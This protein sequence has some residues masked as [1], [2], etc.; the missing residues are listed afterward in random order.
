MGNTKSKTEEAR[1]QNLLSKFTDDERGK[2]LKR[3]KEFGK[4][5][6]ENNILDEGGTAS[7]HHDKNNRP[8]IEKCG[9]ISVEDFKQHLS[10]VIT[11]SLRQGFAQYFQIESSNSWDY[12][13]SKLSEK[14]G[15]LSS[16]TVSITE[17]GFISAIY[18]LLRSN[19]IDQA[20]SAFIIC[21]AS[22]DGGAL[23]TFVQDV[24]R[25]ALAYWFEGAQLTSEVIETSKTIE[26]QEF[27]SDQHRLV[28]YL[29]LFP[30][31]SSLNPEDF[32]RT[33]Q[34][35]KE[36]S[37]DE[38]FDHEAFV[39]WY[40]NNIPFKH[41]FGI[42]ITHIFLE[43]QNFPYSNTLNLTQLKALRQT[44]LISA[45]ISS[46]Y[47]LPNF[48]RL[49]SVADYFVLAQYLPGDCRTSPMPHTLLFSSK[50]DGDS[51]QTFMNSFLYKGSTLIIVR[52]KDGHVFGGFAYQDWE[53][54]PKFFGSEQNF[55]FTIKPRLRCFPASAGYNENWQY[56][57]VGM[58]TLPNGL[59]M[60][61]QLD[62]FALWINSDFVNGHSK[63][64]PLSTT[65]SNPQLSKQAE[66]KIDEVEVWL[67][68]P[69]E[70][71]IDEIPQGG[72]ISI[73]DRHPAELELIEMATNRKMYSK[74]VREPNV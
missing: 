36:S 69:T 6:E 5:N 54:S 63:A 10:N 22:G 44:N 50:R 57:N 72:R 61:G 59:G 32:E 13:N 8:L 43:D 55:L 40:T 21:H 1:L 45:S 67:V 20:Q 30:K 27:V 28:E 11:P 41:L 65:Y 17:L 39:E 68:K 70:R 9:Q 53:V 51:W 18:K 34:F 19:I 56:L 12:T 71:D 14:L 3:Y 42:L 25:A 24:T 46:P 2:L 60:G 7:D 66:F 58:K 31:L 37:L 16:S 73:L 38:Y 48:S 64:A 33:A 15:K 49:I 35:L 47:S 29:L 74:E 62:Y 26:K 52:D 23:K 4:S